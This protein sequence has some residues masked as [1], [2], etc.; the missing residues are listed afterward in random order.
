MMT[1]L[2]LFVAL[3]VL[4]VLATRFGHDSR[5]EAWYDERNLSPFQ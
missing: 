2:M 5:P 3:V 1:L 4:D